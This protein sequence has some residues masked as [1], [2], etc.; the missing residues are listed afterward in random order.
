MFTHPIFQT[1]VELILGFFTLLIVTRVV[2]KTQINQLSPFDFISSIVLGELLG[3]AVY[4]DEVK[5]WSVIFA[6][7]L[8]S[9]LMILVEIAT[10]KSFTVRKLTEGGPTIIIKNGQIDYESLKKEKLDVNELL[11]ALRQKDA[12]S[13]HEV[14][15]AILEPSGNISVL[16][17]SKYNTPTL[18]DFKLDYKKVYLSVS[19]IIDGKVMKNNLNSIGFDEKWLEKQLSHFKV[20]NI[21]DVFYAEWKQDEGMY[22]TLRKA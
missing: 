12:F 11:S 7:T 2:R 10:Q 19:L 16:K 17:K 9:I 4:D 18:E 6:L 1:S 5:I 20:E 21:E 15:F 22:V 13:V 8:W 14:E 3:N